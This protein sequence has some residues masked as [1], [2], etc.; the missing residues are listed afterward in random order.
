MGVS[1]IEAYF[2]AIQEKLGDNVNFVMFTRNFDQ[3]GEY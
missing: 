3:E 1:G 2:E